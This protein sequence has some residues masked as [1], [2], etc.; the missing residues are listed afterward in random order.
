MT[1]LNKF[2]S[3]YKSFGIECKVMQESGDSENVYIILTEDDTTM[4]QDNDCT[5]SDKFDGY[6]GFYTKIVFDKNGKFLI[7]GFWE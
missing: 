6:R 5:N 1:D 3:L 4:F 2:I 7:Q